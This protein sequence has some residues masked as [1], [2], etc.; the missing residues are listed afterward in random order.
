MK[1]LEII[2]ND[3]NQLK[4]LAEKIRTSNIQGLLIICTLPL[5]F[6]N[7]STY[8]MHTYIGG[9]F[10]V[11][12]FVLMSI[13]LSLALMEIITSKPFHNFKREALT[14]LFKCN[15]ITNQIFIY[16]QCNFLQIKILSNFDTFV[17]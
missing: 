8:V 9:I 11:V 5:C 10:V 13:R 6:T 1:G 14:T 4:V 17:T 2:T 16:L 7:I 3:Y 15:F 12:I